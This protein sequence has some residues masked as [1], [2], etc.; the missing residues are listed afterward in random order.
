MQH[1]EFASIFSKS[2]EHGGDEIEDSI[3]ENDDDEE[4]DQTD[5]NSDSDHR[6]SSGSRSTPSLMQ[7][8][9]AKRTSVA[10]NELATMDRIRAAIASVQPMIGGVDKRARLRVLTL[11]KQ[12]FSTNQVH[13]STLL[14]AI[15]DILLNFAQQSSTQNGDSD[16]IYLKNLEEF[17]ANVLSQLR[18]QSTRK[19][20][21]KRQ[22]RERSSSEE[23]N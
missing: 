7:I 8:R 3:S 1:P 6:T 15:C 21:P 18:E 9:K 17:F 14:R 12:Y 11:I 4:E 16:R 22:R 10:S 5:S 2:S 23:E 20:P 19:R 13:F